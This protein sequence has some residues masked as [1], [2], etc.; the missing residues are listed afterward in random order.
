MPVTFHI[1]VNGVN[2]F[3]ASKSAA[4]SASSRSA[5]DRRG[6]SGQRGR[7]H[8]VVR[9]RGSVSVAAATRLQLADREA[10]LR[11]R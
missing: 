6:G 4:G 9:P 3:C 1:E 8:R 11:V 7:Q 5:A 2:R 10:E